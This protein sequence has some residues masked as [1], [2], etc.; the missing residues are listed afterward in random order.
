MDKI[1]LYR[2]DPY[3]TKYQILINNH[4]NVGWKHYNGLKTFTEYWKVKY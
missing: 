4:E 2:Q 1:Y 3:G